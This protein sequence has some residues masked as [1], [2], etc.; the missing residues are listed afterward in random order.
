MIEN[1]PPT[2]PSCSNIYTTETTG[3]TYT[4]PVFNDPEGDP[5]T[6]SV[7]FANGSALTSSWINFDAVTRVLVYHSPSSISS[8]LQLLISAADAYNPP[9]TVTINYYSDFAPK[10]NSSVAMRTGNF[11]C[12]S[13]SSMT[14]SKTILTDEDSTLSYTITYANGTAAPSWLSIKLPSQ[15]SSGNF[16]F[17]GSYSVFENVLYS[18]K[19][20]A[21]DSKG[22]QGSAVF[23]IQTKSRCNFNLFKVMWN[24]NWN[25]WFGPNVDQWTDWYSGRYLYISLWGLTCPTGY[26]P[27]SSDNTWQSKYC[28]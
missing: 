21:T 26:Y 1:K 17:S 4:V 22:Q 2:A 10:D 7:T 15:S 3:G 24:S 11:I 18:F 19:I 25:T 14:L 20:T 28:N 27:Q 5:V 23:Y 8:P 6:Y 13:T 9:T 12:F 16:E